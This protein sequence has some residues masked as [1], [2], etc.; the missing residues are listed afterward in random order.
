MIVIYPG[1]YILTNSGWAQLY[2]R[3]MEGPTLI[4]VFFLVDKLLYLFKLSVN[5]YFF[6]LKIG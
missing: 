2:S 4:A 3:L 1:H 6:Y 5:S